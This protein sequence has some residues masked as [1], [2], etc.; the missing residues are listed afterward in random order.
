MKKYIGVDI[1]GTT[2]KS[3]LVDS[4]GRI[5]KRS[6]IPTLP[7][8]HY[9]ELA[10]DIAAQI[11]E[12]SEGDNVDSIGVGCPGIVDS[13]RGY[14]EYSCNLYWKDVPLADELSRLTGKRVRVC[15][16]ANAAALG[17]A[18][19]GAGKS[20]TDT[21]FIT[22]GTGVGGGFVVDGK[23]F[24]GYRGLGA[25]VGH[26]VIR[27]GGVRCTCGRRGCFE[28]YASATALIRDTEFAMKNDLNSK[29][30]EYVG[31]DLNKV[32]GRT[33]FECSKKGDV[34]A[35]E[36]VDNY[37]KYLA[38]GIA[39]IVNVFRSQAVII[40]GGVSAQG[41]YLTVPLQRRVDAL[42]YG[43]DDSLRTDIVVASLGNDAG[44]LGA[45]SLVM[46]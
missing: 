2:V 20:Y 16:D 24:E 35:R 32:D 26:M 11:G 38:E 18:R 4:D 3:A 5:L 44:I 15:N 40:G 8:R 29:M 9:G 34:A 37:I 17:E 46:E 28:A 19:F 43:G 13:S 1:G 23:L 30:W 12:L 21:T 14:V 6:T 41:E 27:M 39:N 36:V 33:S 10:V 31:G 22:L 42:R 7:T 45:A 25:E